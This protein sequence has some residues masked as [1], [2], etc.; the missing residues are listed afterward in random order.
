MQF[1]DDGITVYATSLSL[2]QVLL[3]AM[4]LCSGDDRFGS[5]CVGN[6]MYS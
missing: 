2:H 3:S 1:P 6:A 5:S 4:K